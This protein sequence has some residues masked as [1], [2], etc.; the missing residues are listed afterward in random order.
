MWKKP[1]ASEMREWEAILASEWL[2]DIDAIEWFW[3]AKKAVKQKTMKL[4]DISKIEDEKKVKFN[5]DSESQSIE[6]LSSTWELIW[7]IK[8][9]TYTYGNVSQ[10]KH[11]ERKVYDEFTWNWFWQLLF[12]IYSGLKFEIPDEE[13]THKPSVILFLQANGYRLNSRFDESWNI[14]ELD[15]IELAQLESDLIHL[16]KTWD[17]DLDYTYKM[18]L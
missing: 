5:I 1:T 3:K 18:V 8:P 17:A 13:Y 11:L 16:R 10:E 7:Y 4:L 12:D 9:G 2:W 15:D 14:I 6:L